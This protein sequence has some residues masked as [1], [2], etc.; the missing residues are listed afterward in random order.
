MMASAFFWKITLT[1]VWE[2]TWGSHRRAERPVGSFGLAWGAV[3]IA[4]LRAGSR[5]RQKRTHQEGIQKSNQ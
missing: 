1:T 2:A 5:D 4:G 3:M